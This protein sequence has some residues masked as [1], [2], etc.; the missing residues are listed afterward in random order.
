MLTTGSVKD[1]VGVTVLRE[2]AWPPIVPLD[3]LMRAVDVYEERGRTC[4]SRNRKHTFELTPRLFCARCGKKLTS[5]TTRYETRK[6]RHRRKGDCPATS[7]SVDAD[8]AEAAVHALLSRYSVADELWA[9]IEEAAST[10]PD[11]DD[12]TEAELQARLALLR[13]RQK[14][15]RKLYVAEELS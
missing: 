9:V 6:Y 14:R 11:P 13:R 7:G 8:E 5:Q 15:L 12:E 3:I 4:P 1:A 2:D 10:L